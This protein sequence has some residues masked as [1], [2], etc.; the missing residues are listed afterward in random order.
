MTRLRRLNITD[1]RLLV[2]ALVALVVLAVL[3]PP[4]GSSESWKPLSIRNSSGGGAM[5]LRMWMEHLGFDVRPLTA[6][7]H[8]SDDVDALF[9]LEPVHTY[10]PNEA[11]A[12]YDWVAA[13]H[14][15]VVVGTEDDA[16]NSVLMPF[17]VSLTSIEWF[18][19]TLSLASPTLT[20]PPFEHVSVSYASPIYTTRADLVVHIMAEG[21]PLF[22][23][24][25]AGD[26][27]VW[28][29]G[30]PAPFTN[31]GLRD[32]AS[33]RL[34]AN[35]L[36]RLPDG[37]TV[38]FDESEREVTVPESLEHWMLSSPAGWSILLAGALVMGY[39]L[40]RGRRFGRIVPVEGQQL[41]REPTEYV[42]AM[43]N[44]MRRTR[45]RGVVLHHYRG[46][47]RRVLAKRYVIDPDLSD[48]AFVRVLAERDST[49]DV[50]A[51][52]GL[53]HR[54]SAQ[55][56]SEHDLVSLAMAV[57]EWIGEGR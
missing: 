42:R 37:A 35:L 20:T 7:E 53:L 6:G 33:A 32:E 46:E 11:Q 43:A 24:L 48:E 13:G 5:V 23:S 39:L 41:R 29:A 36:L 28:I 51:L 8:L 3:F 10:T 31:S 14:T 21:Q 27:M 45:H 55:N 34:V 16:V 4:S 50:E 22:A 26:G 17:D 54:L 40:L 25:G 52:A 2:A 57:D 56:A 12:L 15:L 44:L 18:D 49:L 30:M 38:A 47:L 1:M 9:M 19:S